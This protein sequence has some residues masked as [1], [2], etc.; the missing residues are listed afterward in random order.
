MSRRCTGG[1]QLVSPLDASTSIGNSVGGGL[2][3]GGGQSRSELYG[4]T[5]K[6]RPSPAADVSAGRVTTV[7]VPRIGAIV[8]IKVTCL[9]DK[10]Y[11]SRIQVIK[12]IKSWNHTLL[13]GP[14][15]R[16]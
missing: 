2:Q 15:K 6:V 11:L 4:L 3:A 1:L 14:E 13:M 8:E 10:M 9:H 7:S 16:H 5:C 12:S